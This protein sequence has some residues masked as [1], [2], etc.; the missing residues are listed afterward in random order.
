MPRFA[1]SIRNGGHERM[2]HS[3]AG[4]MR[5]NIASAR[6]ARTMEQR[7]Y[8]VGFADLNRQ[9]LRL[10]RLHILIRSNPIA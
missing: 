3:C 10:A 9:W 5:E 2:S 6:A 1:E 4:T 7:R 8:R